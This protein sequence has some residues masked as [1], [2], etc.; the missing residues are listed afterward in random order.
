MYRW[1]FGDPANPTAGSTDINPSY[2]YGNAGQYTVTLIPTVACLDT[3]KKVITVT[4]PAPVAV[5]A[6]DTNVCNDNSLV[7]TANTAAGNTV[8]W[9]TSPTFTNPVSGN[10]F[11]VNPTNRTNTYYVRATDANG[12]TGVDT[13]IVTNNK[14]QLQ[15]TKA[16]DV[17]KGVA[18]Q[19]TITNL[20]PDNVNVT[21]S[22]SGVVTGTGLTPTINTST[23]GTVVATFTNQVG[24]TLRDTFTVKTHEV[25]AKAAIDQT[26]I[27]ANDE[28]KLSSTPGSGNYTYRWIAD[29][30]NANI[31]GTGTANT[32]AKPQSNTAFTVEITDQ[33]GCKDTATVRVTVLTP[34]CSEPYIFIPRAF[35]PDNG[36][37]LNDKVYVRGEFLTEVE[38]AIYTR[39]GEL[40]FKTNNL[41]TGWDGTHKGKAVNPDVYGYYVKGRCKD[42][43]NFFKKGN[44]TV[45]K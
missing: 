24:C 10:T 6:R 37:E 38:F 44:I 1:V 23:D 14:I 20:T 25:D 13:V 18:K 2:T 11:S 41:E 4:N 32:T 3:V 35:S 21:W 43:Q 9:S 12:C 36:D 29:N 42:G 34:E 15:Y 28:V 17:C 16:V 26:V 19:L 8:V 22:P 39:W 30:S 27:Y 31:T 45:L 33:F 5:A 40:V 7:L